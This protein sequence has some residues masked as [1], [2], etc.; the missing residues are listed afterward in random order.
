[1]GGR[2]E[3][4]LGGGQLA[5][6][7][8]VEDHVPLGSDLEEGGNSRVIASGQGID[9]LKNS[10]LIGGSKKEDLVSLRFLDCGP[11]NLEGL[12]GEEIWKT[13][14]GRSESKCGP[15][16]RWDL[17]ENCVKAVRTGS[18]RE[19]DGL[20]T[21]QFKEKER[22]NLHKNARTHPRSRVLRVKRARGEDGLKEEP[23]SGC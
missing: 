1:M 9:L 6:R 21:D 14:H 7:M 16:S 19:T 4:G 22:M 3:I 12:V 18:I 20:T 15:A 23:G 17:A 10:S 2:L 5:R 13:G 8:V 11:Q